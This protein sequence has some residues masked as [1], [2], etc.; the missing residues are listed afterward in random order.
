[1]VSQVIGEDRSRISGRGTV[2][3]VRRLG[4]R[5]SFLS[6]SF[7]RVYS[8]FWT[9]IPFFLLARLVS[10]L[11]G[12][13]PLEK[14]LFLFQFISDGLNKPRLGSLTILPTIDFSKAFDSVWYPGFF[15]P[16]LSL[17]M[18]FRERPSCLLVSRSYAV[19]LLSDG[20]L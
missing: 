2:G 15:P 10:A 6:A 7:Y 3:E 9:L 12:R 20:V 13:S 4:R 5:G 17:T 8:S 14:M 19:S 18:Y 16:F 11:V 1:M